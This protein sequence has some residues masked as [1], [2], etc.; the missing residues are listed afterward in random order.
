M[1]KRTLFITAAVGVLSAYLSTAGAA[2]ASAGK[3][4]PTWES[5]EK[6]S[7][8]EWFH[9]VKFGIFIHWGVYSVPGWAPKGNYAEWYP[10]NMY[11]EGSPTYQYH[12]ENYGDP[13]EFTYKDFAPMFKAEKW[14]PDRWADLFEKAGAKYVVPVG[15]HHDGFPMWDSDLTEYDV[16]DIGP[17]R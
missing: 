13:H 4:K 9:D 11:K 16:T 15:E 8:P 7:V 2:D 10:R 1:K 17:K 3:Y 12:V 5:L 6:H 14:D